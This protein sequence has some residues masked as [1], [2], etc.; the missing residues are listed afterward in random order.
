MKISFTYHLT[1]ADQT[2]FVYSGR[3]FKKV[4]NT[5]FTYTR[6]RM[7]PECLRFLIKVFK[8]NFMV[9]KKICYIY[10]TVHQFWSNAHQLVKDFCNCNWSV[11]LFYILH[12]TNIQIDKTNSDVCILSLQL[13]SNH[14]VQSYSSA[15]VFVFLYRF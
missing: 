6:K 7:F 10:S 1:S 15:H 8:K 3:F 14:Q 12:T 11:F 9:F 13:I 4:R 2:S 5:I